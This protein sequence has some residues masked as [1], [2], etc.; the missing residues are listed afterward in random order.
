[1]FLTLYATMGWLA[2]TV[3]HPLYRALP[4]PA[5]LLVLGGGTFYTVGAV[6]FAT[7]RPNPIPGRF[8]FHE[9]W[10]VMVIL[11]ALAHYLCMY[12]YVLPLG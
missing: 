10:H 1:V 7:E 3:A 2:A 6:I 4:L 12:L 8:G 9:I 11:G 5:V